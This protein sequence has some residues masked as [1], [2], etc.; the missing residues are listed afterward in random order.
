VRG[1]CLIMLALIIMMLFARFKPHRRVPLLARLDRWLQRLFVQLS[2]RSKGKQLLGFY[3]IATRVG[4]VY[5][6]G[7]LLCLLLAYYA[8]YAYYTHLLLLH[9]VPMPEA[10]EQLLSFFEVVTVPNGWHL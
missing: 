3:Q 1:V 8:Y 9:K 10:V 7:F 4:D 6:V 5:K 2:L